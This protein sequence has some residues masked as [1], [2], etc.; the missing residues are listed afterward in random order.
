MPRTFPGEVLRGGIVR[1]RTQPIE[2]AGEII[3]RDQSGRIVGRATPNNGTARLR[4]DIKDVGT[5]P[6]RIKARK[7]GRHASVSREARII[8]RAPSIQR[9]QRHPVVKR[10]LRTLRQQN[11]HTPTLTDR[12]TEPVRDVVLAFQKVHGLQRTGDL[13]PTTWK[14][15]TTATPVRPRNRGSGTHL[16]VD[17][18]RQIMMLVTDG[19]VRGTLHVSTGKTG[20]TPEGWYRIYAKGI[21]SLPN[22]MPFLRGFGFHGYPS[23]PAYPASHGCVRQPMWADQWTYA[24]TDVGTRVFVYR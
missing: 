9:G 17:K 20:N 12:Y 1:I 19:K 15:V 22:F 24:R 16:E 8:V 3:A 5:H 13:N 10:L 4:V 18:T 14:T 11:F 6:L 21:G 2:Y 7:D 23:V